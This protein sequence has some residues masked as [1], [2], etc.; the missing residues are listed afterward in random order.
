MSKKIK[1]VRGT[2]T[3]LQT[4]LSGVM[5]FQDDGWH[6]N[7][8]QWLA[9]YG[10]IM[11][12]RE[13]QPRASNLTKS[14][15]TELEEMLENIIQDKIYDMRNGDLVE[16]VVERTPPNPWNRPYET[17]EP[18]HLNPQPTVPPLE[19]PSPE[20]I[21]A[22]LERAKEFGSIAGGSHGNN[23]PTTDPNEFL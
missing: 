22:K 6:P 9:I 23:E 4:W 2:I 19:D 21:A 18:Y 14:T 7:K 5:E 20:E 16:A 13:E 1:P 15:M 17:I 10:R 3:E 8:D 12:L 11:G